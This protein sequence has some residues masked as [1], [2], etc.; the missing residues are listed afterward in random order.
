MK[1]YIAK[2][3]LSIYIQNKA[4]YIKHRDNVNTIKPTLRTID[5]NN[6]NFKKIKN[7]KLLNRNERNMN[8][9]K[10]K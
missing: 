10:K 2:D 4:S 8:S 5:N 9:P 3:V 1:N 6:I 7:K